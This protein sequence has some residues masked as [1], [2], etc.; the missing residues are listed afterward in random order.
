M[1]CFGILYYRFKRRKK[2]SQPPILPAKDLALK[3]I[4]NTTESFLKP[5]KDRQFCEALSNALRTFIE[6]SFGINTVEATTEELLKSI[7]NNPKIERDDSMMLSDFFKTCD[8]AKFAS[9]SFSKADKDRLIKKA[10]AF[11]TG[12]TVEKP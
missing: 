6:R 5:G 11:I 10:T 12:A 2:A 8:L 4:E 1:I 7:S 9:H 3:A